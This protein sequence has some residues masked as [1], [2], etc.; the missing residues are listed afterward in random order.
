MKWHMILIKYRI[1]FETKK[2]NRTETASIFKIEKL[3]IN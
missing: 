2:Q 3:M 1:R